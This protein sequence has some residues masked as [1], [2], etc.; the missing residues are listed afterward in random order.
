MLCKCQGITLTFDVSYYNYYSNPRKWKVSIESKNYYHSMQISEYQI[1]TL[2]FMS[3]IHIIPLAGK[4]DYF[5]FS[6]L[7]MHVFYAYVLEA[8]C[9]KL[10]TGN[11]YLCLLSSFSHVWLSV[12]LW[13]VALQ[14]LP[15]MGFSRQE[16]CSGL[17]C[18]PPGDLPNP[19][20][21]PVSPVAP[22]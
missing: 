8:L 22:A 2:L 3:L 6:W 4:K 19:G 12:T 17:P 16:C 7:S 5:T 13:T 14:A 20:I 10:Y 21:V 15:S 1:I 9:G 11:K 18:S